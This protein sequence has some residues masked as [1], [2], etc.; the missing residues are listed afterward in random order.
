MAIAQRD[1]RRHALPLHRIAGA[2]GSGFS[3]PSG[4]RSARRLREEVYELAKRRGMDFVT[5]TDHDTIAGVLADRR[6]ARRV[7]IGRADRALPRRATGGARALLRHH[8]RGPRV[9]AGAPRRRGAVRGIH[10]RARDRVRAGAPLL[11]RRRA[12]RRPPPPPPGGAV[13]R[14]GDP[15]R[16]PRAR[17][18]TGRRRPTWPRATASASAAATTT[19]AWTS[20]APTPKAPAASTP[21]RVPG[22]H[23][24]RENAAR[25]QQGSAAKWAH[26]AIALAARSLGRGADAEVGPVARTR[27]AC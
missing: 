27:S 15:Q 4:C 23:A 2:R 11:H 10:A 7:H 20:G 18:S 13:R 21:E 5:I 9:A 12:A 8:A 25:G 6:P 26:A 24:R 14:V 17:S 1:S 16:R 22:A 19:R 3:A